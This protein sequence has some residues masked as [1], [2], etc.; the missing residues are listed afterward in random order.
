M[1]GSATFATDKFRFATAA[2]RISETRTRPARSGV[3]VDAT[4]TSVVVAA[5][6]IS[7]SPLRLRSP[8]RGELDTRGIEIF[9][10]IG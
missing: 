6:A 4:R 2:T 1:S 7:A 5:A 8:R 9:S 10:R 3:P